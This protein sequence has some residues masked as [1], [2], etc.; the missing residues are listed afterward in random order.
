MRRYPVQKRMR[1]MEDR[2]VM[3]VLAGA[4][5]GGR[6]SLVRGSMVQ[7]LV[8]VAACRWMSPVMGSRCEMVGTGRISLDLGRVGERID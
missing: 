4:G 1:S 5:A 8:E 2:V 7:Y 3:A 6:I